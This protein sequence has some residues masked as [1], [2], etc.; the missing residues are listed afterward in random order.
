MVFFMGESLFFHSWVHDGSYHTGQ[1]GPE[2]K[3]KLISGTAQ[4]QIL[5]S[6]A[7]QDM[8]NARKRKSMKNRG[9]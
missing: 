7:S 5:R 3:G 1:S 2:H 8:L 6:E 9:S 4:S